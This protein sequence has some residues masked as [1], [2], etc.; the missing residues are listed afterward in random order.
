LSYKDTVAADFHIHVNF[1][2]DSIITPKNLVKI[3]QKRAISVIAV[4]DHNCFEG[5]K[6]TLKEAKDTNAAIMVVPGMEISSDHGHVIALFIQEKIRSKK[7]DEILE[8]VDNQDGLVVI[9][10]PCKKGQEFTRKEYA[11]ADLLEGLNG[12]ATTTE[13]ESAIKLADSLCM[14][15]IAGSDS[16]IPFELGR[17]R[18]LLPW[19]PNS[20]DELKKMLLNHKMVKTDIKVD[21]FSP[22]ATHFLSFSVENCRRLFKYAK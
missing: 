22:Y 18:T 2:Q 15:V 20:T 11:K 1:S 4:T 19:R 10:H 8:E 17:V 9:P 16:H 13:N 3:A 5:A 6:S 12:R 7:Y 21:P 14:S